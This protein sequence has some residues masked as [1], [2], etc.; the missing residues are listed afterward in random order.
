MDWKKG[1]LS[2]AEGGCE[3]EDR[4]PQGQA[5]ER[6]AKGTRVPERAKETER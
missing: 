2:L 4:A 5:V 6:G 1:T 3:E